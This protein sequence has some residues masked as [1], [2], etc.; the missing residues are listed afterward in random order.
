MCLSIVNKLIIKLFVKKVL[1]GLFVWI[2]NYKGKKIVMNFLKIFRNV[3]KNFVGW[4]NILK[5]LV[6]L[7]LL[8]LNCLIFFLKN[9]F[10]IM[11][12]FGKVLIR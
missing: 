1:I 7:V 3:I 9:N 10:L 4:F 2:C 12:L 5:L 6:V 11:N 8:L